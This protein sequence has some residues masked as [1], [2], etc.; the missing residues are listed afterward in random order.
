MMHS[1]PSQIKVTIHNDS[2]IPKKAQLDGTQHLDD[3]KQYFTYLQS[4]QQSDQ[5]EYLPDL[6]PDIPKG[7]SQE[8]RASALEKGESFKQQKSPYT[9]AMAKAKFKKETAI[10]NLN[11]ESEQ[12]LNVKQQMQMPEHIQTMKSSALSYIS[13]KQNGKQ[14]GP[15]S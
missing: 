14:I 1:D 5:S 7:L 11:E 15:Y 8:Q 9:G 2:Q 10:Q 6:Q 3:L 13:K 12:D 4:E